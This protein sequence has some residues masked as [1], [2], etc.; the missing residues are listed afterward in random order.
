M[1]PPSTEQEEPYRAMP[2]GREHHTYALRR[3][4]E[5]VRPSPVPY[6]TAG[7]KWRTNYL[8]PPMRGLKATALDTPYFTLG[9]AVTLVRRIKPCLTRWPL[10][11]VSHTLDRFI[12]RY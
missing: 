11:G 9:P 7:T 2:H 12:G 8:R 10:T 6:I 3:L 5:S 4:R 1:I